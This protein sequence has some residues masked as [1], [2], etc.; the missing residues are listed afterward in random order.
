MPY[1][2]RSAN[3]LSAALLSPS[4]QSSW[5]PAS[6]FD[7]NQRQIYSPHLLL[8]AW[9][10]IPVI[11]YTSKG[12]NR[13]FRKEDMELLEAEKERT[14]ARFRPRRQ[15]EM[16]KLP[17]MTVKNKS[18]LTSLVKLQRAGG[19]NP[20]YFYTPALYSS[21]QQSRPPMSVHKPNHACCM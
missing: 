1:T 17:R 16:P 12:A 18:L 10:D 19:D 14:T 2:Q 21:R 11:N 4:W 15:Q 9:L 13:S 5:P 7:S 6:E 3:W 8:I 20:Q